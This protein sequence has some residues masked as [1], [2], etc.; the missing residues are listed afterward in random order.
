MTPLERAARALYANWQEAQRKNGQVLAYE[1]WD[2]A[3][4][5]EHALVYEAV[6][7]VLTAIHD[8]GIETLTKADCRWTTAKDD[9]YMESNRVIWHAMIDVILAEK[10]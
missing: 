10:P 9:T 2:A 5:E 8:P 3:P 6:G 4:P 1:S 7:A